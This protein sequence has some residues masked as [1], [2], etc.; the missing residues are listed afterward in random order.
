VFSGRAMTIVCGLVTPRVVAHLLRGFSSNSAKADSESIHSLGLLTAYAPAEGATKLISR[1]G[2][3]W[4][5]ADGLG[6]L[7]PSADFVCDE[8]LSWTV[9]LLVVLLRW[10]LERDNA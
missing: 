1:G 6:S 5:P 10:Q 2:A 4:V 8:A 3:F 9:L 7:G